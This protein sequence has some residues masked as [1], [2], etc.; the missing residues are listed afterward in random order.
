ML[1]KIDFFRPNPPAVA[2]QLYIKFDYFSYTDGFGF[3]PLDYPSTLN[4]IGWS[5]GDGGEVSQSPLGVFHTL[6]LGTWHAIEILM[7]RPDDAV[8]IVIDGSTYKFKLTDWVSYNPALPLDMLLMTSF[9]G[10]GVP[11]AFYLD[12]FTFSTDEMVIQETS[13]EGDV[14]HREIA[15]CESF[16]GHGLGALPT[17]YFWMQAGSGSATIRPD[18]DPEHGKALAVLTGLDLPGPDYMGVRFPLIVATDNRIEASF[19]IYFRNTSARARLGIGNGD[20]WLDGGAD[21]FGGWVA[22]GGGANFDQFQSSAWQRCEIIAD[23]ATGLATFVIEGRSHSFGLASV[24][25]AGADPNTPME[26]LLVYV[27]GGSRTKREDLSIDNIVVRVSAAAMMELAIDG[28]AAWKYYLPRESF[29]SY[30]IGPAPSKFDIGEIYGSGNLAIVA[31]PLKV[32][33]K[34]FRLN[35]AED[36]PDFDVAVAVFPSR[37]E[38]FHLKTSFWWMQD[39]F[40]DYENF[41]IVS[42][43][44]STQIY[45]AVGAGGLVYS[46]AAGPWEPIYTL[47]LNRWHYFEIEVNIGADRVVLVID[48]TRF[49]YKIT[50]FYWYNPDAPLQAVFAMIAGEQQPHSI[51]VDDVSV[52]GREPMLPELVLESEMARQVLSSRETFELYP[53]GP[54][55]PAVEQDLSGTGYA[56]V[57]G[58]PQ[59]AVGRK[60]LEAGIESDSPDDDYAIIAFAPPVRTVEKV[61]VKFYVRRESFASWAAIGILTPLL[62]WSYWWWINAD[63]DIYD[64]ETFFTFEEETWYLV[65]IE[66]D[67][68]INLARVIIDGTV[69]EIALSEGWEYTIP[70]REMLALFFLVHGSETPH[71]LWLDDVWIG[72]EGT[73]DRETKVENG[74]VERAAMRLYEDFESYPPGVA[75]A[76]MILEQYEQMQATIDAS[77]AFSGT[78]S[79]KLSLGATELGSIAVAFPLWALNPSV[80]TARMRIKIDVWPGGFAAFTFG[81][82]DKD[83]PTDVVFVEVAVID[84]DLLLPPG[85]VEPAQRIEAGIWHLVE[86]MMDRSTNTFVVIVDGIRHEMMLTDFAP[87]YNGEVELDM[88]HV[89]FSGSAVSEAVALHID[90]VGAGLEVPALEETVIEVP[91]PFIQPEQP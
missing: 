8:A 91:R 3:A 85:W 86:V 47:Q 31:S 7:N 60:C 48:G 37:G 20:N 21:L 42:E 54:A 45:F 25:W 14:A 34:C 58:V 29:E 9:Y 1:G 13:L 36:S 4:Y 76:E 44:W 2:I 53:F 88:V 56:D 15:L 89:Y 40:Y 6:Q 46:A 27:E 22:C 71:V 17:K 24:L 12:A 11:H 35:I 84:G 70:A 66:I 75:P 33:Q 19:D 69:H 32:E 87:T 80:A 28:E 62:G 50:D 79:L 63:G 41:G 38:S 5:V 49:E 61:H 64:N 30:P 83:Y 18:P 78:K 10:G 26:S 39:A 51:Y 67:K 72:V 90:N 74:L 68:V 73:T 55:P 57:V 23:R 65:E 43:D 52:G 77:E 59:A 82:I 81:F 16:E